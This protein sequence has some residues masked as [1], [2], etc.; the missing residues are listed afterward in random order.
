MLFPHDTH[1]CAEVQLLLE[2]QFTYMV[3]PETLENTGAG[4]SAT[5]SVATMPV[6]EI[7]DAINI[8]QEMKA[9]A[10]RNQRQPVRLV[11]RM[12]PSAILKRESHGEGFDIIFNLRNVQAC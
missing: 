1:F 3:I 2:V 7:D 8:N 12:S 5:A 9:A 4:K 11:H 10:T 6:M